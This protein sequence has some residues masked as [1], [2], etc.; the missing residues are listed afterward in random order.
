MADSI[1]IFR[2]TILF[3]LVSVVKRCIMKETKLQ[4]FVRKV[5]KGID[6]E[7]EVNMDDIII[8]R[9]ATEEEIAK[10]EGLQ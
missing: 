3:K 4:K 5:I 6:L 9:P 1:A 2:H 10:S 8:I 7:E